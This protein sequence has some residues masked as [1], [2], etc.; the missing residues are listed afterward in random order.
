MDGLSG[1][2]ARLRAWGRGRLSDAELIAQAKTEAER[3]EAAFYTAMS[4]RLR[5]DASANAELKRVVASEAVNLVEIGIA[6]DVL[7][8]DAGVGTF[9]LPKGTALP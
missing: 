5:G 8:L 7:A 4:R 9:A 3:T 6:R 1:W 2:L